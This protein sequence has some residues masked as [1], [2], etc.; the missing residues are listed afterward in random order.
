MKKKFIKWTAGVTALMMA[1]TGCGAKPEDTGG[2]RMLTEP[3]ALQAVGYE[4][5]DTQWTIREENPVDD[6][7]LEAVNRFSWKTA[8]EILR[9]KEGNRNYSPL[10][11][12]YALAMAAQGAKGNT[13][14]EFL[15]LLGMEDTKKLAEECGNLF[16]RL[17]EDNECGKLKMADS[18]WIQNGFPVKKEFLATARADFYASAFQVDF[19]DTSAGEAMGAWVAKETEGLLKPA[20]NTSPNEVLAIINTLYL[21]DEWVDRFVESGN[22]KDSFTTR[23]GEEITCEY[24][25]GEYFSQ[26]Y[27][28]GEEYEGTRLYLK[29]SGSM[30]FML[31]KEGQD[32]QNLLTEEKLSEMFGAGE[33]V[34]GTV[35]LSLPKFSF[36]DSM[37]LGETVQALGLKDA[38]ETERADFGGISKEPGIYISRIKQE[39]HLGINEKGVEAAAYTAIEMEA[40]AAFDPA[41][42]ETYVLDLNRPFLFG[43]ISD[44]GVPLFVGVCDRPTA[45]E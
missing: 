45:A 4:D 43:I 32:V 27:Y 10:S 26:V 30:V 1:T 17:Y 6:S 8:S 13:Q 42:Q 37:E 44:M 19:T 38:F 35:K 18:L 33:G 23:S 12:Y 9:A 7:L 24:M 25:N 36:D 22:T 34:Y 15:S 5:Y 40:G 39:S 3:A 28:Q 29:N 16:R 2:S 20:F 11:L 41:A 14:E 21:N 31:P